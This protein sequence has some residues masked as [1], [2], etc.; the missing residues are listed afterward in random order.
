MKIR[1]ILCVSL[2]AAGVGIAVAQDSSEMKPPAVIQINRE[3]LKPGKSGAVHDRSEAAF[4]NLMNKGKLQGHYIALTSM[5]GKS[6]ALYMTRYPS[7]EAWE[8]DNK[9]FAT[10][11]SLGAELDR[12]IAADGELLEGMDSA[13]LVYDDDLSF[14]PRPDFSHAR[15]YEVTAFHVKLGHDRQFHELTKLYKEACEKAGVNTHWGTYGLMYGGQ[16]GIYLSF[17]HRDSLAEIDR[18]MA[19]VNKMWASMDSE[20]A[21]KLN[22]MLGE[23]VESVQ[24]ELFSINPK[25]SYV[26]EATMKADADFWKPKAPRSAVAATAKPAPA[27]ATKPASR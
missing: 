20:A 25:Q 10:N 24:T 1:P 26:D 17:T 2:L 19:A 9:V 11:A 12:A 27:A 4:V 18:E 6:R 8:N 14:H 21:A 13:V 22:Q 7:F 15:Y 23:T 16:G 3:W 5:S